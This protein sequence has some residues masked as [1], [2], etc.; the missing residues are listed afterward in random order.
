MNPIPSAHSQMIIDEYRVAARHL[1]LNRR[2][3]PAD[4][5]TTTL[6]QT[7][8]RLNQA[9]FTSACRDWHCT[10]SLQDTTRPGLELVP[11]YLHTT[12]RGI[13]LIDTRF[14]VAGS[15]PRL[16]LTSIVVSHDNIDGSVFVRGLLDG[17]TVTALGRQ[18]FGFI[19]R[20][21]FVNLL[22][23]YIHTLSSMNPK[24]FPSG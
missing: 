3:S 7:Y 21:R 18:L 1:T 15:S 5:D 10:I 19:L 20:F 13:P 8:P 4:V 17:H 9:S 16:T 14:G 11:K 6:L 23:D 24:P 2:Q 22:G 12:T